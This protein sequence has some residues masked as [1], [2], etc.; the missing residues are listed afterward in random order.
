MAVNVLILKKQP[1][2]TT[3]DFIRKMFVCC[4]QTGRRRTFAQLFQMTTTLF[5]GG[6]DILLDD[7]TLSAVVT[8]LSSASAV[9][10]AIVMML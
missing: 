2:W 1:R 6:C 3:G 10:L 9:L 4:V 8:T 5:G 7:K